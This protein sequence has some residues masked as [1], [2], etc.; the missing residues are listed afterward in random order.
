[1]LVGGVLEEGVVVAIEVEEEALLGV[2]V[3][4][5]EILDLQELGGKAGTGLL[6]WWGG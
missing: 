5:S 2:E 6:S 4:G 3:D 1:M